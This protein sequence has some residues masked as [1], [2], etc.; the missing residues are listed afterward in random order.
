[1]AEGHIVPVTMLGT[2][3]IHLFFLAVIKRG[4]HNFKAIVTNFFIE[5]L[6]R[7]HTLQNI[8][9]KMTWGEKSRTK[10]KPKTKESKNISYFP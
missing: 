1:M 8:T 2:N 7:P 3:V 10:K 4:E 6:N 9:R 5:I